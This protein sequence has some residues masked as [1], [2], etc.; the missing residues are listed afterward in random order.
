MIKTKTVVASL[1]KTPENFLS[2][3][4]ASGF[5]AA[6]AATKAPPDVRT[7]SPQNSVGDLITCAR[8]DPDKLTFAAGSSLTRIAGELV[9]DA[10]G[11]TYDLVIRCAALRAKRQLRS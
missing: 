1:S 11:T 3:T 7:D 9:K 4:G 2:R 8:A 10:T 6:L 5:I